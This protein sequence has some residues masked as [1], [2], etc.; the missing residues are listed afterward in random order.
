MLIPLNGLQ[1][2]EVASG[3]TYIHDL[4]IAHGDLKGVRC[5]A[6]RSIFAPLTVLVGERPH[7][8][9]GDCPSRG[10]RSNGP[11]RPKHSTPFQYYGSLLWDD[12]LDEP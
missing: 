8:P 5:H 2:S 10:F 1:L 4:G 3:V 9:R 11:D 6:L 12:P 7:R